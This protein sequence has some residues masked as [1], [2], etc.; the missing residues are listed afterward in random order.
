MLNDSV[1][2]TTDPALPDPLV[3]TEMIPSF[4]IDKDPALS[5]TVP[6]APLLPVLASERMPV[7]RAAEVP[8]ID[9]APRTLS[10]TLPASPR[11]AVRL[12]ISPLGR[13]VRLSATT[14]T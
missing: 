1:V 4:E 10:D 8:S 14:D 5:R 6:D 2:T 12:A 7:R 3:P 11:P 13:I 9:R